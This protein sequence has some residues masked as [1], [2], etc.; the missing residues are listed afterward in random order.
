MTKFNLKLTEHTSKICG[1]WME[2][3]ILKLKIVIFGL[4]SLRNRNEPGNQLNLS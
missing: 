2:N 3:G 1:L 4:Y